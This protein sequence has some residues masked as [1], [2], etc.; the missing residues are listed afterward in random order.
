MLSVKVAL[1]KIVFF[2]SSFFAATIFACDNTTTTSL[3]KRLLLLRRLNAHTQRRSRSLRK[4][5]DN[6]CGGEEELVP[7]KTLTSQKNNVLV[8][9]A[10]GG[11]IRA[12]QLNNKHSNTALKGAKYTTT[13]RTDILSRDLKG[14][15]TKRGCTDPSRRAPRRRRRRSRNVRNSLLRLLH[16]AQTARSGVAT[17]APTRT[18]CRPSGVPCAG[19][20]GHPKSSGEL[21]YVAMTYF[22]VNV[23]L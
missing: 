3:Y 1:N 20:P 12:A 14:C 15:V 2:P 6:H 22:C 19:P 16:L 11:K 23:M 13:K 4:S 5:P 9:A 21:Q 7:E 10:K 18:G 8:E 17:F